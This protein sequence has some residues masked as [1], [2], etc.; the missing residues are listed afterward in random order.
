MA[1]LEVRRVLEDLEVLALFVSALCH[2]IGHDGF[3]NG[4][5]IATF[6]DLASTYNDLHVQENLHASLCNKLVRKEDTSFVALNKDE[7]QKLR[8]LIVNLIISTDM[9]EHMNITTTFRQKDLEFSVPEDRLQIMKSVLHAI[10]VSTP[11]KPTN[12]SLVQAQKLA[13]EFK[14]QVDKE[15]SLGMEPQ[16]FMAPKTEAARVQLEINFIDYI[17]QPLWENI[18]TL[19]PLSKVFLN[20][21]ETNRKYYQDLLPKSG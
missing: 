18:V 15:V 20:N 9:A 21:L 16:P 6:S 14:R 10:D 13:A 19:F 12:Q 5:H 3:T 2:D 11:A 1:F 8:K 17:V 4:Y 7:Y